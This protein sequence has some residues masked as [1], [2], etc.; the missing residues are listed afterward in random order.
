MVYRKF[1]AVL[2]AAVVVSLLAGCSASATPSPSA[3]ASTG[4]SAVPSAPT[5]AAPSV[6]PISTA[7]VS[8]TLWQNYGT[9]ANAPATYAFV[10]A[11]EAIH[12]NVTINVVS[13]PAAN[14]FALL[15]AAAISKTG[16]CLATQW[17]GLFTLQDK[18]YLEPL[19]SYI[20][21][22]TL[23]SFKGI[24][25][26]SDNF[27][28]ASGV[29]V[30]PWEMQ[31]YNGFYNKKLF[32][33]AGITTLPK[34]WADLAVVDQKLKAAGI[35]PFVYGTGA[36]GLT[37][38][39]YP[40]YDL[41]YLMMMIPVADWQKLYA[42][43][44]PWTDPTIQ[45]QLDKWVAL[46]AN[47]Y[48]N[49]DVLNDTQSFQQFLAGKA[50]MTLEGTWAISA[51][52]KAMGANVGVFLPP[53]VDQPLNGVVEF[54]GDGFAMTNYCQ[55][56]DV[57]ADFLK[58]L[59]DPAAQKIVADEGL[60]PTVTGSSASDPLANEL[61][62]YAAS[63]GYTRYPMI[64]NVI[65]GEVQAVGATVLVAAFAGTMS[66]H[67]AL[68]KMQDALMALPADRRSAAGYK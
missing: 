5:S 63:Q 44:L 68:Q 29:Y 14:Y 33:Q 46:K 19:N 53:F 67:D 34:T 35:Q 10:K 48:T 30:V 28:P 32:A 18:S 7:P 38:G 16:P 24:Q 9:E 56:K 31:T 41:S 58:F 2:A 11:Y 55:N 17:T 54:P 13:Q 49:Q 66:T 15:T 1:T 22:S 27:N 39:F 45:A 6:A 23:E 57:A 62:G 64:D 37:A 52:E 42:G 43:S 12:P 61:L 50:A 25:W 3:I 47:G 36:Q 59:A 60:I 4:G 21:M 26:G 8:L 40:Y 65:Q 20:P 51:V